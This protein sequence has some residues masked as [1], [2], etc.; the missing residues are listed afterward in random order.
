MKKSTLSILISTILTF[1]VSCSSIK[2]DSNTTKIK[3][4]L[5]SIYNFTKYETEIKSIDKTRDYFVD[6][7]EDIYP[8]I[9]NH[10]FEIPKEFISEPET[11]IQLLKRY[12]YTKDG[13]VKMIFYEWSESIRASNSNKKFKK[14]FELLET[15]ISKQLGKSS[16]KNLESKTVN[17]YDTY[18]DDIKWENSELKAYM[19]RFGDNEN[20][21]NEINMVI[22]IN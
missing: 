17:D 7:S 2:I 22:Y 16:F 19:Y 20:R 6:V 21:H 8:Y 1:A 9:K 11:G 4:E 14:I 5:G 3:L 10:T 12:Y 13:S 18:R 15:E